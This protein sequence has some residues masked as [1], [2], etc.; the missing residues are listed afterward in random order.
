M[1]NPARH[2]QQSFRSGLTKTA[3]ASILFAL[4][5]ISAM[6][7]QTFSVIHA[8][9]G[10]GDGYQPYAGLTIDQAGNLYGTTTEYVGGTAFKMRQV[11]GGWV[12]YPLS[13]IALI[14]YSRVVFG[15]GG[16]LFGTTLE[17]GTSEFCE[18]GCGSVYA[19]TP[20]QTVCETVSCPWIQTYIH[21]FTDGADGGNPN[22]VDPVFDAE[23]NLYGTAA[24]GGSA[25]V[26]VVYEM[27]RSDD[28]SW[29]ETV[30]HNFT[31]P[32]GGY[33][34][35]GVIF[36][37]AGNLYGTTGYGGSYGNGT[38]YELSPDGSGWTLTTLYDFQGT[39]DGSTP[40]ATLISDQAGNL[41]GATIV[42]GAHGGGTV[43][44]LSP[45]GGSW[46]FSLL[47]S[48]TGQ[49]TQTSYP[50]VF[51]ALAQDAAGNLYGAAYTEG[52]HGN[53]A[54]FKLTPTNGTWTYTS[55]H[56]FTGGSDGANPFGGVNFDS[57]GNLFG[58]TVLGGMTGGENCDSQGCG[59][60]WEITP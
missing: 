58:T 56:D 23:G 57:H 51:N 28:G 24:I 7:A 17:G 3:L 27:T 25:G 8:F 41:Y 35:S 42:G 60:V 47:Y 37:H 13:N 33:P 20:Q 30:L 5:F 31:G 40:S 55:L 53:G 12:L 9:S 15:P 43:F 50:G 44:K 59:V 52:A 38:V 10:G 32:D 18:F 54:I 48:L 2:S 4:V 39:T 36:D 14:P 19:L 49:E 6:H 26:G 45:S 46:N 21:S 16:A 22:L 1:S 11:N 29:N 34:Y